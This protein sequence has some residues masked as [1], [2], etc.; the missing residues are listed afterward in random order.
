MFLDQVVV[1]KRVFDGDEECVNLH[2][3]KTQVGIGHS[4]SD[5]TF[6]NGVVCRR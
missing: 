5:F 6:R 4:V 2:G 3:Y 1:F